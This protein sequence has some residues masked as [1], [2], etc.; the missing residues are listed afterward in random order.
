MFALLS[1]QT[2]LIGRRHFALS[3]SFSFDF[4]N[5]GKDRSVLTGIK[6]S[7]PATH[8]PLV[9]EAL[10]LPALRREGETDR[11]SN[12]TRGLT[13]LFVRLCT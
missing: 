4:I 1:V 13:N 3:L 8:A 10:H 9:R 5:R 2:K 11:V 6:R 7:H 12:F